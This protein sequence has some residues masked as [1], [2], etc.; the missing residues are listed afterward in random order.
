[1]Q[2]VKHTLD[3]TPWWLVATIALFLLLGWHIIADESYQ[4]IANTL[5]QGL[6]TTVGVTFAAFS[7]ASIAG[8]FIALAGFS[9]HRI[10]R[11]MSRF[12]IEIIRGVPVLVLLFYIAFVGA[13]EIIKLYNWS[14]QYPIEQGWLEKARTRDFT[15]LWRAI[16]ALSISYSAF[17]AEVF[18]AGIQEVSKGQIEAAQALGLSGWQRFR[19]IILPQA[20][21]KILPP[22]GNDFVAMI[23][24]SAL[25][26]VL[27]VQDITQLGKVYSASTFQFFETY[28]VVAFMYLVL[29]L[30]LSLLIR[31]FEY[32]LR[33]HDR[34]K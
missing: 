2:S 23:K 25:V 16:F 17:I 11:E 15:L 3:K 7:I 33:R 12:Y 6:L 31:G 24:D 18:R 4:K 13:P 30:G 32:Y 21:R 34:Q 8:L 29:T 20:M 1:M 26:S 27:G 5:S 28:N 10:V 9:R 22:L 19:L 14:L